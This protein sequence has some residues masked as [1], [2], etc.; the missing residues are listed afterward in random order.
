MFNL[1]RSLGQK[2]EEVLLSRHATEMNTI[3][4]MLHPMTVSIYINTT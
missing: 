1:T 2:T 3:C 4:G